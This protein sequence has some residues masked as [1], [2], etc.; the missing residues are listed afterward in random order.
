MRKPP[1]LLLLLAVMVI[2]SFQTG[3]QEGGQSQRE[4]L[5]KRAVGG[6]ISS[7]Q[8]VGPDGIIY[9]IG[10]DRALHALSPRNGE[11]IWLYRPG[12]R[13][14]SFLAVSPD[15]TVYI[16]NRDNEIFAVN[17]GG[18]ARWKCVVESPVRQ[19]PAL[20][21]EGTLIFLMDRGLMAA[22]SRK[23]D[24]LWTEELHSTP[25]AS[26][27]IDYRGQIYVAVEEGILCYNL[28][29]DR[30]WAL[31]LEGITRLAVDRKGRIYG[32]TA[33]GRIRSF[34]HS[35]EQLWDSGTEPGEVVSLALREDDVLIQTA[36]G[37]IFRA[38]SIG[39]ESFYQG[40]MPLAP[41]YLTES[42]RLCFF[43][44]DN[45]FVSLDFESGEEEVLFTV[46][47]VP[48]PPLVTEAGL[49]LFGA[50]DWR[51]YAYRGEKPDDGWSQFRANPRR[52]GSLY[53]VLTP[54]AKEKL[55]RDDTR[56]IYYNYFTA[57]E[58]PE[59]QMDLVDE[60]RSYGEDRSLLEESIPFWDLLMM[61]LTQTHDDRT[62]MV[63]DRGYRDNPVVRAEAYRLL[64]DWAV[65]PARNSLLA[66]VNQERDPL[67]L[68]AACYALGQIA[69]DW[70]GRSA[71]AIGKI[72]RNPANLRSPRLAEE[73]GIALEQIMVYNG[74]KVAET[75]WEYY[76]LILE[77]PAVSQDV[78]N[79][80]MER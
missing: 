46:P 22:L 16:Q 9:L 69:S 79:I 40:P 10:D 19:M 15:G 53:A 55:Y 35:G 70:D 72:V 57:T 77:S 48:S 71:D 29:G 67:V 80:L 38:D 1:F 11:D 7:W 44:R 23:G 5:W 65:Y 26:P 13:L 33:R 52:D 4:A 56:W 58:D 14:S 20:T 8:A 21:P 25:T 42:G 43:D 45:R 27:I 78:K 74:G 31:G 32:F 75:C 49:I 41:G 76:S 51:F 28:D 3:A 68:A 17:P 37:V 61:K 62:Y 64:G 50:A 34:S 36:D 2:A 24:I 47:D 39:S 60:V 6:E 73:A 54:E 66:H 59:D 18:E 12:G 30:K 63:G